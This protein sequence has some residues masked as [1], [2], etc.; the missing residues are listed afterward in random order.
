MLKTKTQFLQTDPE[1]LEGNKIDFSEPHIYFNQNEYEYHT[2]SC[3][4]EVARQ[5]HK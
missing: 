3:R 5:A 2:G 4:V 1:D